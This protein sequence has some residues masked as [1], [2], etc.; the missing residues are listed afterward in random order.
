MKSSNF[1]KQLRESKG[2][3]QE[4]VAD[5]LKVTTNTVQNWER[6][7]RFKKPEDLHSLL[8][9]YGVSDSMRKLIVLDV[10]GRKSKDDSA[11]VAE[12]SPEFAVF[13]AAV[14]RLVEEKD[15][16]HYVSYPL[17]KTCTCLNILDNRIKC[18]ETTIDYVDRSYFSK[19]TR[20][21]AGWETAILIDTIGREYGVEIGAVGVYQIQENNFKVDEAFPMGDEE[22]WTVYSEEFDR[23][24]DCEEYLD[25]LSTKVDWTR[26]PLEEQGK[27][28][29]EMRKDLLEL[30]VMRERIL[31]YIC[32]Q[33]GWETQVNISGLLDVG[34]EMFWEIVTIQRTGKSYRRVST[35]RRMEWFLAPERSN[36]LSIDRRRKVRKQSLM[37]S[38][39]DAVVYD[40]GTVAQALRVMGRALDLMPVDVEVLDARE[41]A[42]VCRS[43]T[44][45]KERLMQYR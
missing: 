17:D 23:E 43:S 13:K 21:I 19:K 45:F 20:W 33:G 11:I 4:E 16:K 7:L 1:L 27:A 31:T 18:L 5:R 3:T 12:K 35:V 28:L 41:W 24:F 2:F 25:A 10:Y 14:D 29:G 37:E 8:D 34:S 22:G 44:L 36:L 6:D 26:S 40:K 42:D 30:S 9:L 15:V 32:R 38:Y 39:C